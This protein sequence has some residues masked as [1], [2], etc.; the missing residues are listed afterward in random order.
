[1][2][3]LVAALAASLIG[4]SSLASPAVLTPPEHL[5]GEDQTYLTFPEWFLVHSPAEYA[6]FLKHDDPHRFP[7]LAHVG[8]LWSSY[9]AVIDSTRKYAFNAEYH[10][11]INV[12]AISTTVEYGLK[13]LYE[14][15]FGRLAATARGAHRTQEDEFAAATAQRY[16]DFIRCLLYTSDAADE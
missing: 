14:G 4:L 9:A 13:S 3:R 16:V 2:L 5:R 6:A 1:M 8:Q 15:T 7:L 10:V 12:I 11:M